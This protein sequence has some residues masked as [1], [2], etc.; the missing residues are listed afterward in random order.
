MD[1]RLLLCGVAATLVAAA[2]RA[3]TEGGPRRI[4][5]VARRFVFIPNE[6]VVRKGEPVV[7]EFSAPEVAMVF[8]APTPGL[9]TLIVP[10]EVAK[11]AWTPDEVGRFDFVCD[12][13]CGDGHEGMSGH[14]VVQ[15]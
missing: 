9:R 11:V 2:S 8:F 12:V 15:A 13:F 3:A 10:G 1:R 7:L 4:P 6:I 14:L 5:V